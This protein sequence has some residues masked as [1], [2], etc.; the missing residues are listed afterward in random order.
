M[1]KKRPHTHS[2][3]PKSTPPTVESGRGADPTSAQQSNAQLERPSRLQ[4]RLYSAVVLFHFAALILALSANLFPSRLQDHLLKWF[5]PYL[6]TSAQA[7][8]SMP[9]ELTHAESFDF[10]L[11]VEGLSQDDNRWVPLKIPGITDTSPARTRFSMLGRAMSLVL[12]GDPESEVVSQI[13]YRLL[14]I[15]QTNQRQPLEKVR[16]IRPFVPDYDQATNGTSDVDQ[17]PEVLFTAQ[18]VREGD[19]IVGVVPEIENYRQSK[20]RVGIPQSPSAPPK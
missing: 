12:E 14:K 6:V 9:L 11:Q 13:I 18:I 15:A 17:G 8:G 4:I 20:A 19:E 1:P 16:V 7:Y 10:P 2:K 3:S 5:S